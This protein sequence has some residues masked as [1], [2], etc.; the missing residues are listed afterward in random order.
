MTGSARAPS[1]CR[2]RRRWAAPTPSCRPGPSSP[3]PTSARSTRNARGTSRPRRRT[4]RTERGDRREP[5]RGARSRD[6]RPRHDRDGG[7]QHR[8]RSGVPGRRGSTASDRR[9]PDRGDEGLWEGV[10]PSR[11]EDYAVVADLQTAALVA[12]DG[13]MDWLCLPRFDS[14]AAFAS[15]LGGPKAGRWRIAPL[16]GGVCTRRAYRD[17]TMI[18][19]STWETPEGTVTVLDFMPIR[20]TQPDLI[21]IVVGESGGCAGGRAGGPVRLRAGRAVGAARRWPM[22]GGRRARLL[23]ARL[24]GSPHGAEHAQP[25]GLHHRGRPASSVRAD[26]GSLARRRAAALRPGGRAGGDRAVLDGVDR[27]LHLRR[28]LRRGRCGAR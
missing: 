24:A 10:P 26:L 12:R 28:P 17:D 11:I 20:Q 18:L 3:S 14:S 7:S 13:S 25:R 4:S 5:P 27:P 9:Q 21:R 6:D 19:E 15:L 23:V 2:R 16:R 8:R 22:G 1:S